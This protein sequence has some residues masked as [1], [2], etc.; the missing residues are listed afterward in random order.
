MIFSGVYYNLAQFLRNKALCIIRDYYYIYL[1][2]Q[3]VNAVFYFI[4]NPFGG[5]NY[6]F[7]VY[8]YK[9]LVACGYAGLYY[10]R[11]LKEYETAVNSS[12]LKLGSRVSGS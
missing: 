10:C 7:L 2:K 6:L 5:R 3:L 11:T 12:V 8:P 4:D 1:I 9:L